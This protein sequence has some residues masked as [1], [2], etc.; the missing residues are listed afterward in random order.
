M[1]TFSF[2]HGL[3]NMMNL[4]GFTQAVTEAFPKLD[5]KT[6]LDISN[7]VAAHM[8]ELLKEKVYS[9]DAA[10]LQKLEQTLTAETD[11]DKRTEMYF[12]QI[13]EK[14]RALSSDEQQKIDQELDQELTTVMHKI[15]QDY[16]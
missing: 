9:Q 15:Y 12:K 16:D 11:D 14:Y 2:Y 13:I 1:L 6:R 8:F 4:T 5:E 3:L 10:S 7:K